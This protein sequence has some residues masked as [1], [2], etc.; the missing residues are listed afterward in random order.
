M[1]R[2][3][4]VLVLVA[5]FAWVGACGDDDGDGGGLCSLGTL[6]CGCHPGFGCEEGLTCT[7]TGCVDCEATPSACMSTDGGM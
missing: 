6:D 4:R 3:M 1:A 5:G 2:W 7:E